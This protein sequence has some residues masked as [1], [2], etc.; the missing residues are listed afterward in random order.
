SPTGARAAGKHGAGLLSLIVLLRRT[1]AGKKKTLGRGVLF[2]V[3]LWCGAVAG[4][5]AVG[6]ETD[7]ATWPVG[8]GLGAGGLFT[9]LHFL[10]R[11]RLRRHME[12]YRRPC[13]KCRARM[14]LV[15]EQADD[16]LL[17][18]EE[19]AEERIGG[20]DWE[21]WNCPG[22]GA[23]EKI[24]VSLGGASRC[25]KCKR[26]TLIVKRTT[27]RSATYDHGG[28]VRVDETC[29]NPNCRHHSSHTHSTPRLTRPSPSSGGSR[30]SSSSSSRSSSSS[31]SSGG[32][33]GGRSGGGGASRKW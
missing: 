23:Q 7:D 3:L 1:R 27:L 28:E 25:G 31:S 33:G 21:L 17:S 5:I 29:H 22:C 4:G 18:T 24:E 8:V 32:F 13:G 10:L 6:A 20:A 9:T 14:D 12:S 2:P 15:D 11:R 30:S 16:A 19:Q 26:R